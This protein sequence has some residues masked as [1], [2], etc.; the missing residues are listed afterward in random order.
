MH[1]GVLPNFS[2]NVDISLS[3]LNFAKKLNCISW[4]L[5]IFELISSK[6]MVF[7]FFSVFFGFPQA[8][9]SLTIVV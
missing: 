3:D 1:G 5:V 6:F 9:E 8:S 7:R 2:Y 4:V